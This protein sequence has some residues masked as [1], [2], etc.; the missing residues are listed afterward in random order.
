MLQSVTGKTM[1]TYFIIANPVAGSGA[2]AKAIPKVEEILGRREADF[3]LVQTEQPWHGVELAQNAAPD[4]DVVVALGGDG[5]VNEVIN[6]LVSA[7]LDDSGSAVLGVLGAGRG[8][9]LA[10]A[11]EIPDDLD[12]ACDVLLQGHSR[13]I[14]IGRVIGGE[15]PDGRYF[16]NCVGVGF[17]AIATIEVKKLPRLGGFFSFLIAVLR[18]IILYNQAPIS[19]VTYDGIKITQSS[20]MISIMNGRRLGGGFIMAPD[21]KPD[22]G[23]LDLCIAQ[24]VSR[25][26]V[27]TLLPHFLRGDQHTQK[28]IVTG[29][30]SSIMITTDAGVLPA[31]TDGEIISESGKRLEIEL[32][33]QELEVICGPLEGA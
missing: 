3:Q 9:D 17:D 16:G 15:V 31:Q 33:P 10:D 19:T 28:E 4:F 6:G 1:T 26:R 29:Q 23:L 27:L 30:A 7:K 22:D 8:N 32:L 14:D 20:L 5:T 25:R 11:I 2:G 18:T 12:L 13:P 24:Q 21:S